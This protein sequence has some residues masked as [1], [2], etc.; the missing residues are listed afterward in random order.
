MRDVA[1]PVPAPLG[2]RC[3][4]SR[5]APARAIPIAW[6]KGGLEAIVEGEPV[7]VAPDL[8]SASPLSAFLDEPPV[9][10]APRSPGGKAYVIPTDAGLLVR[11]ARARL[12]RA[13]ALDGTY[14][15]ERACVVS[16]D[17]THVACVRAGKA[18]VG[19]WDAP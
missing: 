16:D 11:G 17:E 13:R 7:L 3:A 5:G 18:W 19:V 2:G 14:A 12:F 8:A 6:G 10:G 15:D 9:R 4:G 1:L